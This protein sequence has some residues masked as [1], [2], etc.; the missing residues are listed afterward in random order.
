MQMFTPVMI[1]HWLNDILL[2]FRPGITAPDCHGGIQLLD[3]SLEALDPNHLYVGDAACVKAFSE[4]CRIPE[5]TFF[6]IVSDPAKEL[7]PLTFPTTV[8]LITTHAPLIPLYNRIQRQLHEYI[9]WDR[10][11]QKVIYNSAGLQEM[12]NRASAELHATIL[13]LNA[14]FKKIAAVY[15]PHIQDS[16]ADELKENGY[17]MFDTIQA[18][19]RQ[20]A[21]RSSK[22]PEFIEYLSDISGNYTIVYLIRYQGNLV[23]RLCVILN[24]PEPDPYYS[25]LTAVLSH[26]IAEYM[27][28]NQGADCGSNSAFGSLAADLIECRLTDEEELQQ[29]L[30]QIQ[31]AVRRYYHVLLVS[32]SNDADRSS[33]PWNY[34]ISQLEYVFPFS[35]ITT[36]QGDILL[37]VR[38]T[39]RSSRPSFDKSRLTNLLNHYNGYA[40]IGNASEFLT[41]LPPVY[42]QTREAIR[43]GR[44]MDPD[45]RI[46]YYEDYSMYHMIELAA[47]SSRQQMG[48]RNLVHLCNNEMIAL[49]LY[50]KKKGTSLVEVLYAYLSHERNTTETAKALFIHRNTMLYK[51]HQIEEIIGESLDDP[52]LRERL[53]FSYHTLSYMRRYQKE[54]ILA[55]KRTRPEIPPR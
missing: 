10:K 28:S 37:L 34:L 48:T 51:I 19:Q 1:R 33:I 26:Y 11:L 15:D 5:E 4:A 3:P 23:A 31:L 55:L 25:D 49:V 20:K 35:N 17:Q 24:G 53:M 44:A 46:Y 38:K 36:Y 47:E 40:A 50:D 2:D 22:D 27:F 14:G 18:I 12:L 54:D 41:S 16:T 52:M 21:L 39:R 13:L 30:K 42:H 43:L 45:K 6:F 7:R 8:T 32:F 29:R 9:S